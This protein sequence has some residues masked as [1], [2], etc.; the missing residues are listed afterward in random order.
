MS[1]IRNEKVDGFR[2]NIE[3]YDSAMEVVEKCK[4]RTRTSSSFHDMNNHKIDRVW[5][6]VESY[7]TALELMRTGYQ[8]TVEKLRS[9]LKVSKNGERTRFSFRNEIQGFAPVVPLTLKG[10]PNCMINMSMKPIKAKVINV[11]YDVAVSCGYSSNEI[12]KAGQK[13]LASVVE[14]ERQGY[15][16]NLYAV[17]TYSDSNSTDMLVVRVKRDSQ[18]LD[19]KRVSFPLTHT[20][21]FRVIGF[22]WYSKVPGGKYRDAYGSALADT[23][24]K[25][26]RGEAA[27]KLFGNN[28]IYISAAEII[29]K[30]EEHIK[31]V[32]TNDSTTK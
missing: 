25:S 24:S 30:D 32:L 22:D 10:V 21:F 18:P 27:K 29:D 28:A 31:E 2:F 19:L 11:Y 8:P 20:G 12:I 13:F 9:A 26:K 23:L 5:H 7:E 14:L 1:K 16:F 3:E 17:Q 6:G 15:R 4:S